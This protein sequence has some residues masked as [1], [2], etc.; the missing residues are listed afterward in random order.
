[1]TTQNNPNT[2]FFHN[3]QENNWNTWYSLSGVILQHKEIA[4]EEDVEI[5][6]YKV[7]GTL[8]TPNGEEWEGVFYVDITTY[9][10][11]NGNFTSSCFSETPFEN[12]EF[13]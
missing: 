5:D 10:R 13:V 8:F 9:I 6:Y 1:M 3:F 12:I 11:E 4:N 2:S 7:Q